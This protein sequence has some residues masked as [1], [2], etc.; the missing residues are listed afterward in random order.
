[1]P[2]VHRVLLIFFLLASYVHGGTI[3]EDS[4]DDDSSNS[5]SSEAAYK[6]VKEGC[7]ALPAIQTITVRKNSSLP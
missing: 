2:S 7:P 6:P 4:G 1:M 5:T 3:L